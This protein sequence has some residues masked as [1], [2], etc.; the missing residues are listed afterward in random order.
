M[1]NVVYFS[2]MFQAVPHLAQVASQLPGTFVSTRRSTLQATRRLYPALDTARHLRWL[3]PFS[4]G[5]RLLK[6]A[7]QSS[8]LDVAQAEAQ[9]A[10]AESGV[11]PPR[12]GTT[13][14]GTEK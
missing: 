1:S 4:Q 6:Q 3:G 8:S 13:G 12:K 14:D 2:K 5:A 9:A 11:W 10:Q 7:E